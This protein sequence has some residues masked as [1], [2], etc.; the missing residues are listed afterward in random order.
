MARNI[1]QIYAEAIHTR[2]NYLQLTELDSGRTTSKMSVLN[3]ITY[4]AAVLIHTYEAML[5]VFQVNIAKTIANGVNGTAPYYA[6]VAKL[7]QFDPI[8]RTGDRLV[9]NPDTYKVEYET[10]NESHRIIAQ[11]SWENYTQDDAIVL[12]VCK[13]ST[14]SND[15]DNGTLYTQLSDAELTAFKQYIAAIKFCGAKIYCQSIPGDMVK[16]HTSQSAPIYYDDTLLSHGQALQN[17]KKSI[18]EYTKD[19]EYDSYISYQKIIDAIQNTEGITDVSAN[20]SIG[21]SLYNNEKGVY[22]NEIKITGRLRSRS[23]YLR[24]FDEDGESTLDE[25]TLVAES[26][27]KDILANMGNIKTTSRNGM[28]WEQVDG[29]WKPTDESIIE[30]IQNDEVYTQKAD[31]QSLKMK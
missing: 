30:K 14:D 12:K 26:E 29:Q 8:S 17:I 1:S 7:F 6:T 15:K 2:N 28:V 4:T 5:D 23:G 16:V 13:A 31:M 27:R 11:S 20:V 25:L 3:C 10:I 9:F 24:V 21:V 19:F 22:N 18:A